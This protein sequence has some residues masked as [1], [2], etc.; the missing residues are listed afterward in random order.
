MARVTRLEP[1][2]TPADAF[3]GI[4][5]NMPAVQLVHYINGI[6][7]LNLVRTDDM[8]VYAAKTSSLNYFKFFHYPDED[9][10]SDFCLLANSSAGLNLLPTHKEFGFFLIVQGAIPEGKILQLMAQIKSISGVQVAASIPQE[11]I[12]TLGFILQDLELH[13]TDLKKKTKE[14]QKPFMPLSEDQ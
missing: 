10:R 14:T 7:L 6:T 11:P 3:I 12:K 2:F 1:A 8:P 13:L 5:T 9:Y 4:V